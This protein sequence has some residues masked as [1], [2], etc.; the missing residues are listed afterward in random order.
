MMNCNQK[1]KIELHLEKLIFKHP[2]NGNEFRFGISLQRL[3]I[4]PDASQLSITYIRF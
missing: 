2:E 3:R 1:I 4:V